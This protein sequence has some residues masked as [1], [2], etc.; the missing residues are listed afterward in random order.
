MKPAAMN[1]PNTILSRKGVVQYRGYI[2]AVRK[3]TEVAMPLEIPKKFTGCSLEVTLHGQR[4]DLKL[5]NNSGN[6]HSIVVSQGIF[7]GNQPEIRS[8][9]CPLHATPHPRQA[10]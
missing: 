10:V 1:A 5:W 8:P 2:V 3:C 7:E 9:T 6:G 4:D